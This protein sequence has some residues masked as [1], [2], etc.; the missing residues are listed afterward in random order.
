MTLEGGQH[1]CHGGVLRVS[2]VS[3]LFLCSFVGSYCVCLHESIQAFISSAWGG[4]DHSY[5]SDGCCCVLCLLANSHWQQWRGYLKRC[6]MFGLVNWCEVGAIINCVCIF[7]PSDI[8]ENPVHNEPFWPSRFFPLLKF[9]AGPY[10]SSIW[11]WQCPRCLHPHPQSKGWKSLS[12]LC[13][14]SE[15]VRHKGWSYLLAFV[16]WGQAAR[17][18]QLREGTAYLQQAVPL[19]FE[20]VI[21]W[22]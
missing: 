8:I 12:I 21:L 5:W 14:W 4:C 15:T 2:L 9:L 18:R 22:R 10:H 16:W 20:R 1:C 11:V 6:R 17:P 19:A 3:L 7:L 13:F